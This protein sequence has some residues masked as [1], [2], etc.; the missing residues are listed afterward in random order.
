MEGLAPFSEGGSGSG[1][2][3]GTGKDEGIKSLLKGQI[4]LKQRLPEGQIQQLRTTIR[5]FAKSL[6][7]CKLDFSQKFA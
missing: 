5:L 4:A 7:R 6:S 3:V 2:L 1:T